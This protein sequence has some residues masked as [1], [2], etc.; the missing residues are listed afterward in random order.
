MHNLINEIKSSSEKISEIVRAMK[1]YAYMDQ[2]PRQSVDIHDGLNDT[3]MMLKGYFKNDIQV[4]REFARNLPRIEA[5]GSELNQVWTNIIDNALHA[6]RENGQLGLKT[7]RENNWIVVEIHDNGSGIPEDILPKIF[8][9]FFTTKPTGQG[10][11]LG[12]YVCHNI[13]VNKHKGRISVHSERGG[14]RFTVKLPLSLA[15]VNTFD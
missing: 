11:G 2:A 5:Y 3:L 10:T 15:D 4:K 14:T 1:S 13:I 9:P 12:L 8:D 7:Y 6:V